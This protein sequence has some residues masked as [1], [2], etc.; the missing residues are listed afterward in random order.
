MMEGNLAE[1]V[2]GNHSNSLEALS[3]ASIKDRHGSGP[4]IKFSHGRRIIDD[5]KNLCVCCEVSDC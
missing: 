4:D 3:Q 2:I 1:G 5:F